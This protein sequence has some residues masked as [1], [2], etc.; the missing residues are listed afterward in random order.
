MNL[1][2]I[3]CGICVYYAMWQNFPPT[4]SW[5]IIIPLWFLMFSAI[6][7][8]T[9]ITIKGI[10]TLYVA[11]PLVIAVFYVA[12]GMIGPPLGLWIPACCIAGTCAGLRS[13]NSSVRRSVAKL[14][15]IVIGSLL[16]F[17]GRDYYVYNQMPQVE[18]DK[19]IP[20][21]EAMAKR[22]QGAGEPS[23]EPELPSAVS[24]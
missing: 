20:V 2:I 15:V 4:S 8:S 9:G 17:G 10:P 21:W 6:R 16:V 5:I 23:G 1:S 19:F 14:S 24:H 18:K 22:E 13:E 7:T 12:P 3:A 11:I